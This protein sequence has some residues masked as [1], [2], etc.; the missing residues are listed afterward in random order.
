MKKKPN[1]FFR[2]FD[3]MS[4]LVLSQRLAI[5]LLCAGLLLLS[6]CKKAIEQIQQS[7]LQQYFEDN[8]LNRSFVVEL[9]TDNG[10]I[11]TDEFTGY[12]FVLKKGTDLLAGPMTGTKS[13]VTFTGTWTSNDDYGKLVIDIN[14][15]TPPPHFG[16]INRSWRFTKKSL[17]IMELAP[18]GSTEPKVLHMRR[19]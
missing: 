4:T 1:S 6:S 19:L 3:T 7:T 9:A 5:A 18:W 12:E 15:P 14:T 10:T 13:G 2:K 8:I 16:F 11:K 17:P